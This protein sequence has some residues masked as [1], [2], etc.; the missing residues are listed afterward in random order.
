MEIFQFNSYQPKFAYPC[1]QAKI[2]LPIIP[3]PSF[4]IHVMAAAKGVAVDSPTPTPL[5]I[6]C[7]VKVPLIVLA[8]AFK[9]IILNYSLGFRK[10]HKKCNILENKPVM[11]PK[12]DMAHNLY[13]HCQESLGVEKLL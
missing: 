1:H 7:V 2:I 8:K 9:T 6:E 13:G 5:I 10:S 3:V 12:F 4:K 11:Y